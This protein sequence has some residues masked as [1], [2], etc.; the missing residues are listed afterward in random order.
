[1]LQ[2]APRHQGEGRAGHHGLEAGADRIDLRNERARRKGNRLSQIRQRR[3]SHA[4]C[5]SLTEQ[6]PRGRCARGRDGGQRARRRNGRNASRLHGALEKPGAHGRGAERLALLVPHRAVAA[7]RAQVRGQPVRAAHGPRDALGPRRGRRPPERG[8]LRSHRLRTTRHT[9]PHHSPPQ[10]STPPPKSTRGKEGQKH[11]FSSPSNPPA[12]AATQKHTRKGGADACFLQ[13]VKP[14]R[15]AP[16][17]L[18]GG[19]TPP[20]A[21]SAVASTPAAGS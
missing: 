8:Q 11:A 9:T 5:G 6:R 20:R 21:P 3:C 7:A 16:G 12:Y 13:P 15:F 2:S 14:F 1:M 4:A 10:L 18:Q 19:P 17:P